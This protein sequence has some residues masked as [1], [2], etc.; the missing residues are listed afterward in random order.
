MTTPPPAP[1]AVLAPL[2]ESAVFL[3][4]VVPPGGEETVRGLLPDLAGLTRSVGFRVP[5]EALTCVAGIGSDLWDRLFDGPRP[6]ELHPFREVTGER[7]TAPSTPG[8]LF[9]HVR[10]LRMHPCFELARLVTDR[11]GG[12]ARVVDEVQ[13]FRYFDNRDLL[14]FVD[15]TENPTGR[16]AAAAVLIGDEDPDFAGGTYVMVQKYLHDLAAW[17]AL[18]VEQRELAVGRRQ[19]DDVELDDETKPADSHVALTTIEDPD[20]TEREILRDNM[21]FGSLERGEFGT[22]FVGYAATPEVPERM[23]T[24]MVVGDPPG[25]S[26]RI[27]E[28]SRAVTGGLFFVPSQD[29]LDDPPPA[30]ATS[31]PARAAATAVPAPT[32]PAETPGSGSLGIG[33]LR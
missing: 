33:S 16:G 6:A 27:L 30:P 28:V 11:L 7:H 25:S 14:G 2:T 22:Y 20:G 24:R 5:D 17:N 29:L 21:P 32:A 23:L 9:L 1:Q 8:D 13:G 3:S 18:T 26:D 15:G 19:L 4:I 12:A 31:T 10:A